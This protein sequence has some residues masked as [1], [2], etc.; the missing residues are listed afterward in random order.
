VLCLGP[1]Y[2]DVVFPAAGEYTL[3]NWQANHPFVLAGADGAIETNAQTI[4]RVTAADAV[5]SAAKTAADTEQA[6]VIAWVRTIIPD[7]GGLAYTGNA[8]TRAP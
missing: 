2:P 8:A 4:A 3:P 1:P 6:R 5:A 7:T